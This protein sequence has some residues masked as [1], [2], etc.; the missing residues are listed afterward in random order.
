MPID[1]CGAN[2][3]VSLIHRHDPDAGIDLDVLSASARL[4]PQ[5]AGAELVVERVGVTAAGGRATIVGEVL[6]ADVELGTRNPDGS[7]GVG[8][9]AGVVLGGVEATFQ[10][11][12]DSSLTLG[13]SV[14]LGLHL[15]VGFRDADH[16]GK[17]A[18][19][20]RIA[21]FFALAGCIEI[22]F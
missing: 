21:E 13:A 22:P 1:A 15:S 10:L 20:A 4:G 19:C 18:V 14:G 6:A 8:I 7:R 12:D 2:P 5:G 11:G 16:D 3:F 17:P 9:G